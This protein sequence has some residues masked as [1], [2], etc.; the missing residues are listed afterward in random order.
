MVREFFTSRADGNLALHVGDDPEL[1]SKNRLALSAR[2][3]LPS[4]NVKY[5]NQ[6]HGNLVG[7][8]D[9]DSPLITADA[10]FTTDK[11]IALVV[12]VADCIPILLR[13]ERAIAAVH[14]GRQGLV[15][16]I[17]DNTINAFYKIGDR[18]IYATIGPAICGTC[19]E[20]SPEMYREVIANFP[21]CA[22][23]DKDHS[24]D[25]VS[26]AIAQLNDHGVHITN[27]SS[28]TRESSNLYSFRADQKC[29]R[30]AGVISW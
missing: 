17:I 28:C 6:V 1:V 21:S 23:N 3:G 30:F 9:K 2:L 16:K 10:L 5:M 19:Y 4:H 27:R 8:V 29:G 15:K 12:L 13:S 18:D 26:G 7:I 20:V 11:K 22:T 25:L 24:L 14:V